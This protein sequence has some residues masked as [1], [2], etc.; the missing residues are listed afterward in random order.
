ML[1]VR[2]VRPLIALGALL[3]LGGCFY[4]PDTIGPVPYAPVTPVIGSY[5][6]SGTAQVVGYVG[7][8]CAAG[9]YICQVP[10][11]PIGAECACPGLGAPSFG[12]IR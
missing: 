4:G 11:G 8:T 1:D 12:T 10:P 5:D 7:T 2:S 6:S 9:F 3:A